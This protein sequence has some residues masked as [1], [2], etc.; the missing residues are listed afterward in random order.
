MNKWVSV[1]LLHLIIKGVE[2]VLFFGVLDHKMH[3]TVHMLQGF[4]NDINESTHQSW[5]LAHYLKIT[6]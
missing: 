1:Y 3:N 6:D 4:D 5:S 2:K